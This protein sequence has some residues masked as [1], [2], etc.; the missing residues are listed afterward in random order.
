M[1][2]HYDVIII[3]GGPTGTTCATL[4]SRRGRRVLLLEREKFPRFH[5]G[6]SLTLFA[7]DAFRCLGVYDELNSINYVQKRGLEFV[8]PDRSKKI[9]FKDRSEP[10][11][12]PWAFQM[13]R[14]KLDEVLLRNA[15]RHGA[16]IRQQHSVKEVLFEKGRAVGVSYVDQSEE[17]HGSAQRVHGRWI[18]DCSGQSAVLN[19]Q[20][21]HNCRNDPLLSE[22]I[23]IFSHWRSEIGI[24]NS[25][26]E[27]NFKLCVHPNRRDW[28][29]YFPIDR[30]LVSLGV[31]LDRYS[32]KHRAGN[33]ESLFRHYADETPFVREF[34]QDPSH[35]RIQKFRGVADFSYRSLSYSG[36]GWA[37]AGDSAGFLDPIFSTGLQIAFNSAFKLAEIIDRVLKTPS[38][39]QQM[40]EGYRI[41][42]DQLYRINSTLVHRFYLSGIDYE[43]MESGWYL[44]TSTQWASSRY[45]LRFFWHGA[46][47]ILRP[48]RVVRRW[49]RDVL[50]GNVQPGNR[51]AALFLALAENDEAV[52][53]RR[54]H[55]PELRQH[56]I[57][58]EI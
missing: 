36:D 44:L 49:A 34:L 28:F 38:D 55:S 24:E 29:W 47:V 42:V 1:T 53:T 39:A 19:R 20:L 32:A 9:Y 2:P 17:P 14:A 13:A 4:L 33:L 40:L 22:K 52:L 57:E 23:A 43:K 56:F 27:L 3:G 12:D 54:G 45:L 11:G 35:R 7:A 16:E 15:E 6:E 31:V 50:F 21:A 48:K 41:A 26:V 37:L 5:I 8:L 25:E 30:N 46:N 51:I 58:Q 18:L 10:T